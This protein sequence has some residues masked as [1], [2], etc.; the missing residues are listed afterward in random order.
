MPYLVLVKVLI[1]RYACTQVGAR[2]ASLR[3][4]RTELSYFDELPRYHSFPMRRYNIITKY[5][6]GTNYESRTESRLVQSTGVPNV[7]GKNNTSNR[8]DFFPPL[9][10]ILHGVSLDVKI[11]LHS[12]Y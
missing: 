1:N 3:Q 7:S 9:H 12:R 11:L 8:N 2:T 6:S 10:H 4:L 5:G